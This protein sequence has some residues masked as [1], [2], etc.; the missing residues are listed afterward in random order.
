MAQEKAWAQAVLILTAGAASAAVGPPR[1]AHKVADVGQLARAFTPEGLTPAAAGV[2]GSADG[3]LWIATAHGLL[4]FDGHHFHRVSPEPV[5]H[6]AVTTDG[7][8]FA[9]GSQGLTAYR[10]DRRIRLPVTGINGL[11]ARE[12]G[13]S[14]AGGRCG[15][16]RRPAWLL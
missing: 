1:A 7:W 5:A 15:A 13:L 11:A 2:A 8:V 4:R 9:G 16:G 14:P 10:G 12:I 6:V 3:Y